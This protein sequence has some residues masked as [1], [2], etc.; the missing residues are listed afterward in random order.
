MDKVSYMF[1]TRITMITLIF[2]CYIKLAYG[3]EG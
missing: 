1:V 3:Y 2:S